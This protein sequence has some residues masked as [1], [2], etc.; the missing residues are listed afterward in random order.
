MNG[1][2]KTESCRFGIDADG[3]VIHNDGAGIVGNGKD[4]LLVGLGGQHVQVGNQEETFILILE[5]KSMPV[6]ANE[7]A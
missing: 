2:L 7:V 6:A 1:G 3:K 5:G 4:A